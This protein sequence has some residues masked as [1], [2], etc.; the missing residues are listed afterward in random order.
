MSA[1]TL[2]LFHADGANGDKPAADDSASSNVLTYSGT[3]ALSTNRFKFGTSSLRVGGASNCI[4]TTPATN[5]NFGTANFTIEFWCNLVA[6]GNWWT[7]AA[8][9]D[10]GA[11]SE[12]VLFGYHNNIAYGWTLDK[13]GNNTY[14][15]DGQ[16][17]TLNQWY[18]LAS[19]RHGKFWRFYVDGVL[20]GQLTTLVTLNDVSLSLW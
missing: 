12:A 15:R 13:N 17:A 14:L 9:G 6:Q 2:F 18:H 20:Q 1:N 7:V 8:L 11:A 4:T 5:F 16:V 19:V 10:P 3:A